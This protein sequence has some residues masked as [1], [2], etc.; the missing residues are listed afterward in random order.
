MTVKKNFAWTLGGPLPR[1]EAH[2][3]RKLEV[4]RRYLD[5]YFDTV[6]SIPHMDCLKIA[7][8]DGFCGGGKYQRGEET[9]PGSPLII[10]DAVRDAQERLNRDRRKPFEIA[11][12]F[13]FV[14][15]EPDHIEHLRGVIEAA[16]YADK[17]GSTIHLYPGKFAE[18]LPTIMAKI[19]DRQ[20][21]GRSIFLLDQWGY[22]DV[23][24]A[25][26]R[27][28]FGKLTRAEVLLTFSIDALLNYLS[29]DRKASATLAQFGVDREFISMWEANKS[30]IDF[31]RI[32][33][34]R[35]VMSHL[36]NNSQ[37]LFFT[38]FMLFSQA[39]GR[40]MMFAHLSQHQTARDKM[41]GVHWDFQNRFTH[42][43]RGSLFE[44]GFDARLLEDK[45]SLFRFTELDRET[46][47]GE[48]REELPDKVLG[49]LGAGPISL[50]ELMAVLGNQ[51]AARNTDIFSVLQTLAAERVLEIVSK[52]GR[53]K[54]PTTALKISDRLAM[55]RQKTFWFGSKG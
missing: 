2:S 15:D 3:E 26:I 9:I 55:P 43:G 35:A 6:A 10:L 42:I 27:A 53:E 44:L 32:T 41:L 51:T 4:L 8:V 13:H 49:M 54:R 40:M 37:A 50:G 36:R 48:L 11:A 17:L 33:A 14:D 19:S 22:L 29:T 20:R 28:I 46:M 23:P 45:G 47:M 12:S 24:M 34:Q 18:H 7:I 52:E 30:D 38:P 25:S 39:S 31:S 16:G 21:A 5:V 1:I